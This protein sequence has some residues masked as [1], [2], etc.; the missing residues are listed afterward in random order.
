MSVEISTEFPLS[1]IDLINLLD[2]SFPPRCIRFGET[3]I[4][5]H[6]YAA[7]REL[8]DELVEMK[9]FHEEGDNGQMDDD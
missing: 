5:A 1:S 9:R 3:E 4:Q 8:I 2:E 7:M 6:R